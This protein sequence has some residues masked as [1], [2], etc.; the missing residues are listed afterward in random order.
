MNVEYGVTDRIRPWEDRPVSKERWQY[1]SAH[2]LLQGGPGRRPEEWWV[3]EKQMKPPCACSDEHETALLFEMGELGPEEIAELEPQWREHY[4][5]AAKAA[6][7]GY[8][9][10]G[11]SG[12]VD[13]KWVDHSERLTG[14]AARQAYLRW[15][16]IPRRY[17]AEWDAERSG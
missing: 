1:W 15:A 12:Y 6:K 10:S 9:S 13:G 16:G 11:G 8:L 2:L 14:E 4:A 5:Q 3:Y 17:V 7:H